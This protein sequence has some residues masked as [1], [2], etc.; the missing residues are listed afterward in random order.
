MAQ[1]SPKS[2]DPIRRFEQWF[3]QAARAKAPLTEAMALGT[4]GRDG[5][6]A[7]R[8][9]L[10]KGVDERGFVFYTDTRSAKGHDLRD[11]PQAAFAFYWDAIGKQVRVAGKVEEVSAAESDAY[12]ASRPRQSRLSGSVSRQSAPI[13]SRAE[14][15]AAVTRLSDALKG[16]EI[17]RP[18]YWSGFRI[19]PKTIEFWTRR[20]YRLHQRE[21]FQR[22]SK[23][24]KRTL[25]QP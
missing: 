8:F 16:S 6:V 12:W 21:L 22:T 9:V 7:V 3:A 14:L 17:P 2:E 23:G 25:L 15:V 10:L 5:R 13:D 24:W 19:V 1:G 4:A 11:N 20:S 18:S